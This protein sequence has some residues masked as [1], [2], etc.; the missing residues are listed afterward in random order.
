M[1]SSISNPECPEY[2]GPYVD[3]TT[4]DTGDYSL[5]RELNPDNDVHNCTKLGWLDWSAAQDTSP[6]DDVSNTFGII[7]SPGK[8]VLVHEDFYDSLPEETRS[9]MVNCEPRYDSNGAFFECHGDQFAFHFPTKS[10]PEHFVVLGEF[11]FRF[12]MRD[13]QGSGRFIPFKVKALVIRYKLPCI[14]PDCRDKSLRFEPM[15]WIGVGLQG[16]ASGERSLVQY[17]YQRDISLCP[18]PLY[19]V[20]IG[21]DASKIEVV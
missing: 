17:A 2:P 15:V 20:R 9:P 5:S 8:G 7:F 14:K 4:T 6:A 19:T 3:Y 16:F 18:Y 1:G 13:G 12:A 10:P 11:I 21:R